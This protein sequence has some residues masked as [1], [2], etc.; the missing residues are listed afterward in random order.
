M[1]VWRSCQNG[2]RGRRYFKFHYAAYF[3][4]DRKGFD[5]MVTKTPSSAAAKL[6]AAESVVERVY[7]SVRHLA[8]GKGDVRSRLKVVGVTLVPLLEN[9]FPIE[10]REDFRWV[11]EQLTRYESVSKEGRIEATMNRIQNSTGEKIASR[12]FEIYSKLQNIRRRP[13]L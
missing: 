1:L 6:S 9:E 11:M 8:V 2:R 7:L 5:P 13:L 12:I 3:W 4:L 10:L